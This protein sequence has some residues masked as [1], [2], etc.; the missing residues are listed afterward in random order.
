MQDNDFNQKTFGQ[1]RIQNEIK[2]K[3]EILSENINKNIKTLG[4]GP[5]MRNFNKFERLYGQDLA[6]HFL[7]FKVNQTVE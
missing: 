6:L 7:V 5:L 3:K 4:I 1:K 2:K